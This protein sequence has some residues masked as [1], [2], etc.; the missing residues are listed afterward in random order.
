MPKKR[1]ERA[2]C[3]I[4]VGIGAQIDDRLP[5]GQDPPEEEN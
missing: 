1:V 5:I 2:E 4:A 3:E